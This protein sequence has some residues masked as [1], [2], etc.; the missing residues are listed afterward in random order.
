MPSGSAMLGMVVVMVRV[1]RS[2]MEILLSGVWA[3]KARLAVGSMRMPAAPVPMGRRLMTLRVAASRMT[4]LG[5]PRR[6]TRT[7][8]PSGVNFRR[9]ALR[10]SESRVSITFL[11]A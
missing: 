8:L 3:M 11:A 6:E 10:V 7:C 4:R 9:L 2:R 5:L 1:V